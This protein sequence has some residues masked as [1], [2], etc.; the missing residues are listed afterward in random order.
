MKLSFNKNHTNI[1]ICEDVI[2]AK[3]FIQRLIG[4]MGKKDFSKNSTL[5]IHQCNSIQTCFMNFN[6][7]AVFVDKNL[8]VKKIIFN[9]KP[10]RMSL[11]LC[12]DHS[13]FE[14]YHGNPVL[15]EL[16]IGDQIHVGH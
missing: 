11:P 5:W 10:W 4:L 6:I 12:G 2:I 1:K 16:S 13:V 7:D 3:S 15:H 9:M 14:F 8:K